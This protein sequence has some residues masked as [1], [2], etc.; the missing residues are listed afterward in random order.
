MSY[1]S[2]V[3]K[4]LLKISKK[5][6]LWRHLGDQQAKICSADEIECFEN[7]EDELF[8]GDMRYDGIDDTKKY[9]ALSDCQCLPQCSSLK[10]EIELVKTNY[11]THLIQ[12]KT[13][14]SLKVFFKDN[15]FVPLKRF[16]LYGTV[17]FLA[18]CGRRENFSI[19][20]I[21]N[22]FSIR[23]VA[24]IICWRLGLIDCGNFLLLHTKVSEFFFSSTKIQI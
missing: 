10:Y 18:N 6:F 4:M 17:D 9:K 20:T 14:A 8:N 5:Y 15:E 1:V 23:W 16:Q 21:Y 3:R 19:F 12:Y 2:W 11:K 13:I 24:W 22:P 7:A